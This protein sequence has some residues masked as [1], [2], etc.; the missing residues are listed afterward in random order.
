MIERFFADSKSQPIVIFDE[1]HNSTGNSTTREFKDKIVS[2]GASCVYS[3]ATFLD[4]NKQLASFMHL[5]EMKPTLENERVMLALDNVANPIL[6]NQI[7][8]FLAKEM[9]LL[10]REHSAVEKMNYIQIDDEDEEEN[11]LVSDE[12]L[13]D[14]K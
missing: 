13:Y 4:K 2:L 14:D 12:D 6:D 3:S 1:F 10:R 5:L 9:R 7:A 8:F 11:S